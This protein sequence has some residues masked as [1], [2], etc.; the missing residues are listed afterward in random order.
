MLQ[1]HHAVV[2]AGAGLNGLL[3]ANA[4]CQAGITPVLLDPAGINAA[5]EESVLT[6][7]LSA[8]TAAYL[9]DLGIWKV[10]APK[11]TA[12]QRIM[13][14]D[15]HSTARTHFD[16]TTRPMG[17]IVYNPDLRQA[18]HA[19]LPEKFTTQQVIKARITGLQRDST[20]I[21]TDLDI[22]ETV[23]SSLLL[24]SDG[25]FSSVRRLA[26][27]P[28]THRDYHQTAI[29]ATIHTEKPHQGTAYEHFMTTG[30]IAMLPLPVQQASLV[31]T[32]PTERAQQLAALPEDIFCQG[33]QQQFG[34]ALGIL[35]LGSVRKTYP[36]Q[37]IQASQF[38][39]ERLALVGDAAHHVHPLA[40]Q[41]FN[42]G[43]RD[44]KAIV[45]LL[46][47]HQRLGLDP[48]ACNILKA[49]NDRR[50]L[51]VQVMQTA[52][53]GLNTLFSNNNPA[54]HALR[55]IG[56]YAFDQCA[57]LKRSVQHHA[58]GLSLFSGSSSG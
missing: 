16:S 23:R 25:K 53:H 29:V 43:V 11:A 54:L 26:G 14:R 1:T 40:G 49:Y 2:V 18:L 52:L 6:T 56:L 50:Q 17:Y 36:L 48:G 35:R 20:S 33:L 19:S 5:T 47:T 45:A 44:T 12:I 41:G 13:V 34:D 31:W 7:A 24:A 4:L 3:L 15:G 22:G 58:M 10:L 42:L 55:C 32:L 27:I 57:P 51:D 28:V 21:M 37:A 38:V 46:Q 9:D 39:A 8:A 30:P